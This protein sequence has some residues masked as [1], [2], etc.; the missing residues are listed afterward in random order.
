MGLLL[1]LLLLIA[2]V[3]GTLGSVFEVAAAVAIGI[4]LAFVVIVGLIWWRVRRAIRGAFGTTERG[5]FGGQR[6]PRWRQIPGSTVEV[7]DRDE[8][9]Q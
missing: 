4:I 3:T 2:A 7:L 8:R 5:A 1:L 6:Q 9:T